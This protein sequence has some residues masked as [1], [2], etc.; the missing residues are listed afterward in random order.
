[1]VLDAARA[2]EDRQAHINIHTCTHKS[3]N[4]GV[5]LGANQCFYPR[6]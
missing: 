5:F 3:I 4:Q 6:M 1:M 2:D